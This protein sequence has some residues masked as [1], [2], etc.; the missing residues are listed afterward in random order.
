MISEGCS[1]EVAFNGHITYSDNNVLNVRSLLI[2]FHSLVLF[3]TPSKQLDVDVAHSK[4]LSTTLVPVLLRRTQKSLRVLK[5]PPNSYSSYSCPV[6]FKVTIS[7]WKTRGHHGKSN[8]LLQ[9]GC[10]RT[11]LVSL[12]ERYLDAAT[13]CM[14]WP[15]PMKIS[16]TTKQFSTILLVRWSLCGLSCCRWRMYVINVL[17]WPYHN[18]TLNAVLHK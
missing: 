7:V 2:H 10:R 11:Y 9:H 18:I 16:R 4:A 17:S 1:V 15:V 3:G 14:L 5:F 12:S 8:L 13:W 6:Q